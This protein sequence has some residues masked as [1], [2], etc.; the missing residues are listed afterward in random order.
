MR[1]WRFF[2]S[3]NV[4]AVRLFRGQGMRDQASGLMGCPQDWRNSVAAV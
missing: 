1:A 3:Q 4:C 2:F